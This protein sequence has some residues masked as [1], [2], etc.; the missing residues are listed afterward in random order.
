MVGL[1]APGVA[2]ESGRSLGRET[3]V[4]KGMIAGAGRSLEAPLA[5]GST[6]N[7]PAAGRRQA[8]GKREARRADDGTQRGRGLHV[9]GR[10]PLQPSSDR[11]RSGRPDRQPGTTPSGT[12]GSE[13]RRTPVAA[14]IAL[15]IA[16]AIARIGVSPAPAGEISGRS[17]RIIS[18]GGT[19]SIRSTR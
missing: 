15:A 1:H 6:L 2:Q 3:N 14:K 11:A 16:G 10:S 17:M 9:V 12:S 5:L 4:P 8:A 19:S 7:E 13:R 18:T